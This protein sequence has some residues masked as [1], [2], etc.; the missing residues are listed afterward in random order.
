MLASIIVLSLPMLG[1]LEFSSAAEFPSS[2]RELKNKNREAK[3]AEKEKIPPIAANRFGSRFDIVSQQSIELGSILSLPLNKEILESMKNQN[4][5]DLAVFNAKGELVPFGVFS[6]EQPDISLLQEHKLKLFPIYNDQASN[7]NSDLR[8]LY[9]LKTDGQLVPRINNSSATKETTQALAGYILVMPA[10]KVSLKKLTF[11][12]QGNNTARLSLDASS[13]LQNWKPLNSSFVL[14]KL[15]QGEESLELNELNLD[16]WLKERYLRV[17]FIGEPLKFVDVI[18]TVSSK[19]TKDPGLEKIIATPIVPNE[20]AKTP[21]VAADDKSVYFDLKGIF[22]SRTLN[23]ILNTPGLLKNVIIYK[24][25]NETEN[26]QSV[27]RGNFYSI[28]YKGETISNKTYNLDGLNAARYWKISPAVPD[29]SIPK[30]LNLELEY[31]PQNLYFLAQGEGPYLLAS[32]STQYTP[33]QSIGGLVSL[34]ESS[35]FPIVQTRKIEDLSVMP[36]I[37]EEA[38]S[39]TKLY[40]LWGV[41]ALGILLMIYIAV[42]LLKNMNANPESNPKN[43]SATANTTT[44]NSETHEPKD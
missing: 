25:N 42:R 33:E 39:E 31:L 43:N 28:K 22:P 12:L 18:A 7:G 10:D 32:G 5:R 35:N 11:Q 16:Y 20:N 3:I 26:W 14:A 8:L 37:V 21:K 15:Q 24:R 13:D 29:M 17:N 4:L 27:M 6:P 19:Q 44:G 36:E 30:D 2:R 1:F 34:L 38:E 23:I 40:L 41:L 9:E